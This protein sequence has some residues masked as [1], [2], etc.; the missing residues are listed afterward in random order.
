MLTGSRWNLKTS[1]ISNCWGKAGLIKAP[2]QLED[3]LEIN[4]SNPGD[5][6]TEDDETPHHLNGLKHAEVRTLKGGPSTRRPISPSLALVGEAASYMATRLRNAY[7]SDGAHTSQPVLSL[8]LARIFENM[9]TGS[10]LRH[11]SMHVY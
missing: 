10:V 7:D 6:W 8:P 1:T 5:L 9:V 2:V 3:N 11:A 4:D